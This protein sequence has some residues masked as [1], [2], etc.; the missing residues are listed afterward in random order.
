MVS[1]YIL[2][3]MRKLILIEGGGSVGKS[4]IIMNAC[5]EYLGSSYR[6]RLKGQFPDKHVYVD[7]DNRRVCF[8]S[9][10]YQKG[11]I[12]SAV[13]FFMECKCDI[14]VSACNNNPSSSC[15][16][17]WTQIL[18]EHGIKLSEIEKRITVEKRK[19]S[20]EQEKIIAQTQK[21]IIC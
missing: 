20:E 16:R 12:A 6:F 4:T 5:M 15:R 13:N 8:A 19:D 7:T 11:I 14:A 10:A 1:I 3:V 18:L 9:G 17:W 2:V 21:L